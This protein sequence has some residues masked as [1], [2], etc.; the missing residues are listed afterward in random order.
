MNLFEAIKNLLERE[1]QGKESSSGAQVV[2]LTGFARMIAD[3]RQD[4]YSCEGIYEL[5]DQV[6]E[7]VSRGEDV[8]QVMPLVQHH[9]DFCR[10][11]HEELEALMR[12]LEASPA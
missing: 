11:C 1:G 8:S 6:A 10:D 9:L 12:I 5:I 4:E 2:E 3:T 7:M